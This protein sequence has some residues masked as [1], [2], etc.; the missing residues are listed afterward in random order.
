MD[1]REQRI[2]DRARKI[3][4]DAGRADGSHDEHW[5]RAEAEHELSE[6]EASEV[7]QVNQ[8]ANDEFASDEGGSA[9][10]V[11]N[12]PPSVSSAD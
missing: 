6:Q 5:R 10:A 1:D 8:D 3:W 12:R 11:E 9:S 7:T 2:R 4:E